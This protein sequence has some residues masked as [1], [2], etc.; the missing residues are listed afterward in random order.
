M[1]TNGIYLSKIALVNGMFS[2]DAHI[3]TLGKASYLKNEKMLTFCRHDNFVPLINKNP[4]V[5]AVICPPSLTGKFRPDIAVITHGEPQEFLAAVSD[6]LLTETSFYER[7]LGRY[8]ASSALIHP[9]S[10]IADQDVV[11][12]ENVRIG[13]NAIIEKNTVIEDNTEIGAGAIIGYDHIFPI[14]L[15]GKTYYTRHSGGVLIKKN[16]MVG[17][18][19]CIYKAMFSFDTVIGE[20]TTLGTMVTIAH[21]VRVGSNCSIGCNALLSGNVTVGDDIYMGPASVVSNGLNIGHKAVLGIGSLVK[22]D[23]PPGT[24]IHGAASPSSMELLEAERIKSYSKRMMN[25]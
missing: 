25:G 12:G 17:A 9:S 10:Q 21:N 11:I 20:E 5:R 23:V 4:N 7:G 16:A 15:N 24:V 6:Y 18:L 19:C 22:R 13:P 14:N 1:K 2:S 8:I 3:E